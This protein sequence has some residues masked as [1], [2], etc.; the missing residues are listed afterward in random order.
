MVDA[1]YAR[2]LAAYGRP[3]SVHL[4][5]D[6]GMHRLGEA[7]GH[8]EEIRQIFALPSLR[9]QGI[10]TH[11][12]TADGTTSRD[13]AYVHR[14]AQAF[15]ELLERLQNQGIALPKVHL[16]ASHGLLNHPDLGGTM[17]GWASPSTAC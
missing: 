4:A 15:R 9:I 11:L 17:P 6:T 2:Q 10:Y 8:L 5:V 14:Q 12:C 7:S 16:L 13:Q 1:A 3:L